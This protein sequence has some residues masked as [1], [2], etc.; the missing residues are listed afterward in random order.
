M[1]AGPSGNLVSGSAGESRALTGGLG[2]GEQQRAWGC[3]GWPLGQAWGR[4]SCCLGIYQIIL[5]HCA[6]FRSRMN[7]RWEEAASVDAGCPGPMPFGGRVFVWVML[8]LV[9]A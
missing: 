9:E 4:G 3:G 6:F 1:L 2:R 5:R 8:R 7:K